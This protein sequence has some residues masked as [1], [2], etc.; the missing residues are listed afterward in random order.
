MA[1]PALPGG[2]P[3]FIVIG[4]SKCGTSSFYA[5]L[6][7][8]P[9]VFV[10]H[11]KE[12]HF[13]TYDDIYALGPETF[14]EKYYRNADG[15]HAIGD[16][17]PTYFVRPDIVIP[18]I[19]AIYGD[20]PPK[21]I[22]ILRHPVE[23][24]WSHYLHKVRSG[25]ETEPFAS[26]L[27]LENERVRRDP[28][29]WWGYRWESH[30]AAR[31]DAWLTAFP[32]DRFLFLLTEDLMSRPDAVLSEV[33]TFLGV[34]PDVKI[35]DF[36]RRNAS[37]AIRSRLLLS[38]ISN[39]SRLKDVLRTLLPMRYRQKLKTRLI[40][41]NNSNTRAPAQ[42]SDEERKLLAEALEA[43][44]RKLEALTGIDVSRWSF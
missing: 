26:A 19:K 41:L 39:Q 16:I 35:E 11:V 24:A 44:V 5:Y 1:V 37:G 28:M 6:R 22:L 2:F 29:G 4:A 33:F 36:Q 17:T 40:E 13:F 20:S 9:D 31:L 21:L 43:D 27:R 32:R 25:E 15:K 38:L 8:H 12:T 14:V 10:S 34:D 3:N 42:M 18:R 23:R 30:Y 7:Q